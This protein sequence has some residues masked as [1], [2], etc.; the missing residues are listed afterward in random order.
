MITHK[1]LE[2]LDKEMKVDLVNGL[3]DRIRDA[4]MDIYTCNITNLRIEIINA[5]TMMKDLQL[6]LESLDLWE[7][8][9]EDDISRDNNP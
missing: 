5:Y 7:G 4:G 1:T 2:D 3:R 8:D 6:L 9:D